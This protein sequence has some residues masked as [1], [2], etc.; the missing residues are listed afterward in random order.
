M[1]TGHSLAAILVA[2]ALVTVGQEIDNTL[3]RFFGGL[4][5]GYAGVSLM[6]GRRS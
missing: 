6:L 2:A 5:M 4:L 3:L 1:S